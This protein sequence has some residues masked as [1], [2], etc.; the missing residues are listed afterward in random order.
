MAFSFSIDHWVVKLWYWTQSVDVIVSNTEVYKKDLLV[1]CC[2]INNQKPDRAKDLNNNRNTVF[3]AEKYD[4]SSSD[5]LKRLKYIFWNYI[6][7]VFEIDV[8]V[9]LI[10]RSHFSRS[11]LGNNGQLVYLEKW[12]NNEFSAR[13]LEDQSLS[14]KPIPASC[15]SA[16]LTNLRFVAPLTWFLILTS[17]HICKSTCIRMSFS[18]S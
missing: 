15:T 6:E 2:D 18:I 5:I 10:N 11:R 8:L 12:Q 7:W 17:F 4:F 9:T 14:P 13:N 16:A 1:L 3:N